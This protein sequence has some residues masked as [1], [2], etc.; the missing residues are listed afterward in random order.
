MAAGLQHR[1]SRPCQA[2]CVLQQ[3]QARC[4]HPHGEDW[5]LPR[6]YAQRHLFPHCPV[7]SDSN[8][9]HGKLDTPISHS[10]RGVSSPGFGA[11]DEECK[12]D[13]AR[14]LSHKAPLAHE[15]APMADLMDI[16]KELMPTVLIGAAAIKPDVKEK[17]PNSFPHQVLAPQ[18]YLLLAEAGGDHLHP[19]AL[20]PGATLYIQSVSPFSFAPGVRVDLCLP[21]QAH[22][23][24]H[25]P[26]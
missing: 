13:D 24:L 15:H 14:P 7:N 8:D 17:E 16:V 23:T 21:G 2:G 22:A 3:G 11:D 25:A 26:G 10:I 12:E 4:L 19:P 5:L 1:L 20:L 6:R 9:L 18:P